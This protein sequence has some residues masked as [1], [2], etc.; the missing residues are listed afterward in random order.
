M[1][2]LAHEL[3][4]KAKTKG[5]TE[6]DVMLVESDAFSVRVRMGEI[7]KLENAREH[8]LGLRLFF[9]KRS[10]VTSTSDLSRDSLD[11]LLE[12]T[13]VLAQSTARDAASGLPDPGECVNQIPDL[14]LWDDYAKDLSMDEKI[15]LAK[16][17]EKA[18]LDFDSRITNS[19]GGSFD[20][21]TARIFY[22]NSHGFS[23]QYRASGFSVSVVPVASQNGSMQRDYWYS[24]RRKFKELEAA[25]KVGQVAAMR[26]LRRLG[27]RK[28]KTQ[29][30]PVVFDPMMGG[31]LL[32]YLASS[33]SG[34]LIYKGGSFQTGNI[35]K[36]VAAS[37][38]T[39]WDDGVLPG[40]LGSKPFDGE[41][42]PTR[43]ASV[44]EG[45]RLNSYLLDTYSARKLGMAST[46]NAARSVGDSPGVS[47]HN[48]Y[49]AA[50]AASPEDIIGSVKS[51][52][53]VT[54]LIG[55]GVN[56]ATGDFSQGAAGLWIENGRLAFPVEEVTI[57]GNLKQMFLDIELVGNDLRLDRKI[58]SPTLKISR[59]TIAGR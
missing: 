10:A 21:Y 15:E 28:V 47:P 39:L 9:G 31:R 33:L 8:Q 7:D 2:D 37:Q 45:G 43:R 52:L 50:G 54:E 27:A 29:T 40:G 23:G 34:H 4:K 13:C 30:A 46:G 49:L 35:G 32:S 41:G 36:Q 17:A 6:G 18:A 26:T 55:F 42:I 14:D 20:H 11:R 58:A 56:L 22:S 5:A 57:A 25:E 19:E 38:V 16:R 48:F 12:D 24:H 53:Y 3:L 51:G 44:I 59:M 1:E